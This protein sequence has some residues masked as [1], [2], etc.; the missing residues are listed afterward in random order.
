METPANCN[1]AWSKFLRYCFSFDKSYNSDK[2]TDIQLNIWSTGL[3]S[4]AAQNTVE[5]CPL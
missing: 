3:Y 5:M 2:A 1:V 4:S